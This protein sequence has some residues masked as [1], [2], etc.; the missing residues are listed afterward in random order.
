MAITDF[1]SNNVTI[2][3]FGVPIIV[4][5]GI[6]AFFLLRKRKKRAVNITFN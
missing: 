5:V 3:G 1:L 4:I 6:G 2:L